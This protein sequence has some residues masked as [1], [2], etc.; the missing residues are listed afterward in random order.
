MAC[1]PEHTS[2]GGTWQ[3]GPKFLALTDASSSAPA[4]GGAPAAEPGL[5]AIKGPPAVPGKLAAATPGLHP[6]S[7]SS[8]ALIALGDGAGAVD[9]ASSVDGSMGTSAGGTAGQALTLA[10]DSQN[11]EVQTLTLT[12]TQTITQTLTL[13]LTLAPSLAGD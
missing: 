2:L 1:P 3:A 7:S 6:P 5:L 4:A 11:R 9:G 12:L 8:T 10:G 13:T